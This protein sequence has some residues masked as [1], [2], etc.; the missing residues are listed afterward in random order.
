[1]VPTVYKAV[2]PVFSEHMTAV[3]DAGKLWG[4]MN[5]E[6]QITA[7]PQFKAVLTPFSEGLAGV[8]TTD[9]NGYARPDGT[10][11]FMAEF[12]K[13]Y[14]FE[15]GLA[16]VRTGEVGETAVM[17]RFPVT[18]GIGWGWGHWYHHH[19]HYHHPF[20]WGI[21][22][23]YGIPGIMIMKRCLPSGCSGATSTA[24]EGSLPVLPMTGSSNG[25]NRVS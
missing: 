5:N 19:H 11:A 6:G 22:F 17:R 18:I 4:F 12:D 25:V 3:E 7:K 10:I 8:K 20:G 21:G 1:M 14:P 23:P 15:E 13:L 9:G 24:A 2:V 16:E